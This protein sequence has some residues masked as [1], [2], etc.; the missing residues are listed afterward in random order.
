[1]TNEAMIG[2]L[3]AANDRDWSEMFGGGE[4]EAPAYREQKEYNREDD[5]PYLPFDDTDFDWETWW[6][7]NR[8]I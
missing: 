7:E 8:I 6:K 1:M 3:A 4:Y 5:V 2:Q